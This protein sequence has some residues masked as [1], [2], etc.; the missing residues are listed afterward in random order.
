MASFNKINVCIYFILF[1]NN[2]VCVKLNQKIVVLQLLVKK[3]V[4]ISCCAIIKIVETNCVLFMTMK[5][6]SR[7]GLILK[8]PKIPVF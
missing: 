3:C 4:A 5:I 6:N 2:L 8:V 7:V 1:N